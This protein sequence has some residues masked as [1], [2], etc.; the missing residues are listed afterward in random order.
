[1]KRVKSND[2]R[3][4]EASRESEI[5][6]LVDA[7]TL[8]VDALDI[9]RAQ[10]AGDADAETVLRLLACAGRI[11]AEARRNEPKLMAA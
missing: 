9:L 10:G 7:G 1:M 2:P 11:L 4:S 6:R 8:G 5:R 3:Q